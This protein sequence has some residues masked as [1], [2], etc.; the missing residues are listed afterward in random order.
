[1]RPPGGR[2]CQRPGRELLAAPQQVRDTL[3]RN[4]PGLSAAAPG[5]HE[6]MPFR[7]GSRRVPSLR[8]FVPGPAAASSAPRSMCTVYRHRD[9]QKRGV[10]RA[11]D[12]QQPGLRLD[13]GV[14]QRALGEGA[15]RRARV[16]DALPGRMPFTAGMLH[17]DVERPG[18]PARSA[19]RRSARITRRARRSADGGRHTQPQRRLDLLGR[20]GRRLVHAE[21]PRGRRG[22][23]PR[24]RKPGGPGPITGSARRRAAS[25]RRR[26]RTAVATV[27]SSAWSSRER[28]GSSGHSSSAS[29]ASASAAAPA[30]WTP[31]ALAQRASEDAAWARVASVGARSQRRTQVFLRHGELH[32]DYLIPA[33]LGEDLPPLLL[34]R[35]LAQRSPQIRRGRPRSATVRRRSRCRPERADPTRVPRGDVTSRCAAT[36]SAEA[37]SPARASAAAAC[38]A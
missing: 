15:S 9:E 12:Q 25:S 14:V 4:G 11:L 30:E 6:L 8:R 16:D 1:M 38:R 27:S 2:P 13:L 21:A 3:L 24:P 22:S 20:G 37:P 5:G 17:R 26:S 34:G 18:Q 23:S 28:S 36:R 19:R 33:E 10:M 31:D 32:R 29:D 35:G 7:S